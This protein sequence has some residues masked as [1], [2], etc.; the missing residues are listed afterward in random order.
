MS[1]QTRLPLFLVLMVI[2][3]FGAGC[4]VTKIDVDVYKGPLANHKDVQMQ[5]MSVMAIGAKPLLIQL[6]DRLEVQYR[7][8]ERSTT[9]MVGGWVWERFEPSKSLRERMGI[10]YSDGFIRFH[11]DPRLRLND[12]NAIRVNAVLSLYEDRDPNNLYEQAEAA[13]ADYTRNWNIFW[14]ADPAEWKR[15]WDELA[16]GMRSPSAEPD[17]IARQDLKQLKEAFRQFFVPE[18]E[19]WLRHPTEQIYNVRPDPINSTADDAIDPKRKLTYPGGNASFLALSEPKIVDMYAAWLFPGDAPQKAYFARDVASIASAFL[20]ARA[21]LRRMLRVNL[22]RLTLFQATVSPYAHYDFQTEKAKNATIDLVVTLIRRRNFRAVMQ[23]VQAKP[24]F[25]SADL[26]DLQRAVAKEEKRDPNLLTGRDVDK[27]IDFL[28]DRLRTETSRTA[29]ALL[30]ADE[31]FASDD[32]PTGTL[33]GRHSFLKDPRQRRFGLTWIPAV[34]D[35]ERSPDDTENLTER[36]IKAREEQEKQKARRELAMADPQAMK[37]E[38]AG[39]RFEGTAGFARGRLDPGLERLIEEYLETVHQGSSSAT[40][41]S[42][43]KPKKECLLEALARFATKVL[44][45]ADNSTLLSDTGG[46]ARKD[47]EEYVLVLQA[48]GNSILVQADELRHRRAHED[49]A[50]ARATTEQHALKGTLSQE[51]EAVL[52]TL[53]SELNER[54][55]RSAARL[56]RLAEEKKDAVAAKE[57]LKNRLV[58]LTDPNK[59]SALKGA[60]FGDDEVKINLGGPWYSREQVEDTLDELKALVLV[61]KIFFADASTGTFHTWEAFT[62]EYLAKETPG[63]SNQTAVEFRRWFSEALGRAIDRERKKASPALPELEYWLIAARGYI[64]GLSEAEIKELADDTPVK[65]FGGLM[66]FFSKDWQKRQRFDKA[67]EWLTEKKKLLAVE[68]TLHSLTEEEQEVQQDRDLINNAVGKIEAAKC[69]VLNELASCKRDVAPA[70]IFVRLGRTLRIMKKAASDKEAAEP[71]EVAQY[72]SALAMLNE[73]PT[74]AVPGS[75]FCREAESD[76]EVMDRLMATLRQE[77]IQAV[78]MYGKDSPTAQRIEAAM[79]TAATHRSEMAYIRP[80]SA[81]LRSSYPAASLQSD[82]GLAWKNLLREQGFRSVW[83]TS[84]TSK[85]RRKITAEIDKQFWQNINSVRVSGGGRTNYVIAKDDIGNWYVKAYSADPKDIIKGAQS[86]ALYNMGAAMGTDLLPRLDPNYVSEEAPGDEQSASWQR[87]GFEAFRDNYHARTKQDHDALKELSEGLDKSIE[88]G[89]EANGLEGA[90]EIKDVLAA[91]QQ[92]L[93][94]FT[95]NLPAEP[96][97]VELGHIVIDQLQELMHFEESVN[98]ALRMRVEQHRA[99][100]QTTRASLEQIEKELDGLKAELAAAEGRLHDAERNLKRAEVLR[101][102][103]AENVRATDEERAEAAAD[104]VELGQKKSAASEEADALEGKVEN[105]NNRHE[106]ARTQ[107]KDAQDENE[108]KIA[109]ATA[110]QK[111]VTDIVMSDVKRLAGERH[112]MVTDYIAAIEVLGGKAP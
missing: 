105:A 17:E 1:R 6:R 91:P 99:K 21:A 32:F 15:Q 23:A 71:N 102:L 45:I 46:S 52:G 43:V 25:F 44:F 4:A 89:W 49:K 103:L 55:N 72:E 16:K 65:L 22:T 73:I 61:G 77:H 56:A 12:E 78:H 18:K 47:I 108:P 76:E 70:E 110:A 11:P 5:Q 31:I 63:D 10:A 111:V 86:L 9:D 19:D 41:L 50:G 74:L 109:T 94:T 30:E 20:R 28:K 96:A 88:A 59:T 62:D 36:E 85:T 14:G 84:G 106:N 33:T 64:D 29:A 57:K 104:V 69:R 81:Y 79:A 90:S 24:E 82:P 34:Y 107:Y 2:V 37:G 97:Q 54:R 83:D 80:P 26:I 13:L 100:I 51:R 87:Q 42:E 112:T 60:L 27:Y 66:H 75:V 7:R 40:S 38:Q 39:T 67:M 101:D 68:V 8:K 58:V 92:R 48:V 3:L 53:M 98:T 95:N 35:D 93:N